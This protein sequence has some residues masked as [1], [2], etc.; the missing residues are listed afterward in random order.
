MRVFI[1]YG[2]HARDSWVEECV[3]P[4][5]RAFGCEV[6]HGRAVFGGAL[7]DEVIRAIRT[8]DAMIGFT[9]RREPVGPGQ[10][11]THPWV[12]QELVTAHGQA[13]RIPFVEV[14]EEGVVPPGGI[15]DA[16]NAQRIEY[17]EADRVACLVEIA[18][19]LQRFREETSVIMV[20]LGPLS[21]VDQII[22]LLDDASFVCRCRTL[23]DGIES[24]P[25]VIPV[26]PIKG[27]LFVQLRGIAQGEL[28]RIA[29]SA[30]GRTWRSS[31]ESLD[32]V[33]VQLQG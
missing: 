1:G 27:G 32:T 22:P 24:E 18:K 16:V 26:F 23:R 9:T 25:R 29:L 33:D 14:R 28:V 20:R 13:P 6:V 3:V 8:A 5:V 2:Y 4:F 7:P 21:V 10:F 15:L 30:G 11:N 17:R 31:Y 19:S 12:V